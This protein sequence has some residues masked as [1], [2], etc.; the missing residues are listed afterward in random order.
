MNGE[1]CFQSPPSND[2]HNAALVRYD[3]VTYLDWVSHNG[4]RVRIVF[5]K[6]ERCKALICYLNRRFSRASSLIDAHPISFIPL[7]ISARMRPSARS[8]PAW[9]AA[10]KGNR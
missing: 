10:A 5:G 9:P 3:F 4:E 6:G 7:S 1:A 2:L 8:T